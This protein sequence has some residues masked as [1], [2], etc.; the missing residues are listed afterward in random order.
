[1]GNTMGLRQKDALSYLLL[2]Q[3]AAFPSF[4]DEDMTSMTFRIPCGSLIK[5]HGVHEYTNCTQYM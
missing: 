2:A 1:M 4:Y 3:S 5:L